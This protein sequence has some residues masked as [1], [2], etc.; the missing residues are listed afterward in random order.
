MKAV[1][2]TKYGSP[3]G[4]KIME[5]EKPIPKDNEVLIKIH[6]ATVIAGDC[7]MRALKFPFIFK[8][9]M[10]LMVGIT[11]PRG[12]MILGQEM[13]GEI[14]A[15]G[16][17]VTALK[18]GDKVFGTTGFKFSTYAEYVCLKD[19]NELVLT[20]IPSNMSF[21][22]AATIPIGG[23]EAFHFVSRA[24][25]I[26]SE[27][28]VLIN[29]AGGSIGTIAIQLAKHYGAEVTVVDHGDKL[30]ML[31]S[32]GA[33]HVIDYTKE[34]FTKSD[35]VYDVILDV[36]GKSH[37]SRSLKSLT[38]KGVYINGNPKFPVKQRALIT[39][40]TSSKTVYCKITEQTTKDLVTLRNLIEDGHVKTVIDKIFALDDI[41]EAHKY[42][43]KGLKQG[44]LVIKINQD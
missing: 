43:D 20:S 23:L 33:D 27:S 26:G 22:E 14:E 1:V 29:G 44:N 38:E 3:E 17:D 42:V 31:T 21:E 5:L 12:N 15:I 11:K 24:A 13:S 7:E 30:D 19:N 32:I 18:V 4:L 9:V 16:K 25:Q 36:I 41:V 6:A 2:W 8:I 28:K 40:L 37:Y 39:N 34:D 35:K 10:R